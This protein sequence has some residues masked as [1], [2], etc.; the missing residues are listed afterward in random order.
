MTAATAPT[1]E[2]T[3]RDIVPSDPCTVPFDDDEASVGYRFASLRETETVGD[4]RAALQEDL[5]EVVIHLDDYDSL[6][7]LRNTLQQFVGMTDTHCEFYFHCDKRPRLEQRSLEYL[8]RLDAS[9]ALV[10][11]FNGL[12]PQDADILADSAPARRNMGPLSL[13]VDSPVFD[14]DIKR[15][16]AYH[17]KGATAAVKLDKREVTT[18]QG[19]LDACC[20]LGPVHN[21]RIHLS[22]FDNLQDLWIVFR[23][24][25]V[26][27]A[28][29]SAVI[30]LEWPDGLCTVDRET[31]MALSEGIRF[32]QSL[33]RL[34]GPDVN[35]LQ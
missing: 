9:L 30:R 15:R 16:P 22:K 21:V 12:Q 24:L 11:A 19:L 23:A 28:T 20:D 7:K 32:V 3:V 13:E 6:S 2:P 5:A 26:V 25:A 14:V 17:Y 18:Y 34:H 35:V 8:R 1:A 27:D 29:A 4:L 31:L 10:L 33:A